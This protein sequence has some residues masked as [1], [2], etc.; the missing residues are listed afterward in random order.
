MAVE[1]A[2]LDNTFVSDLNAVRTSR[3][4][5]PLTEAI[6]RVLRELGSARL[7]VSVVTLAEYSVKHGRQ[8]TVEMAAS[9]SVQSITA[10]DA[11]KC[12]ELGRRMLAQRLG[13]NDEWLAAQALRG[14]F[15]LVTR[16]GR[17]ADVTGLKVLFYG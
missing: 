2:L 1:N 14:G 16:D 3:R 6:K 9:Y 10:A 12:G 8:A 11:F 4:A 7:F 15:T 5:H 17:F 13:E